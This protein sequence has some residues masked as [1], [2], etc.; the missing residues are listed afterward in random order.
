MLKNKYKLIKNK[1]KRPYERS[2]MFTKSK[3][4]VL[5]VPDY[6]DDEVAKDIVDKLNKSSKSLPLGW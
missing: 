6:L 4:I 5:H 2:I 3:T 1:D